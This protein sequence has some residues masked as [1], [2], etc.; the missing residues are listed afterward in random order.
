[1]NVFGNYSKYYD[2]LYQDK[3]YV[4]EVEYVHGLIQRYAS[5]AK[6]IIELGCGTGNHANLLHQKGYVLDGIDISETMLV[7]A[8]S[9]FPHI[10]FH[11]GDIREIKLSMKADVV[12][13][14]FHV[15]S[16]Q[17]TNEDLHKT[18]AT[19]K[20]QLNDGGIFIFDCWY[21]PAVLTNRPVVRVAGARA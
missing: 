8:R 1:M 7:E 10:R 19:V 2:L 20:V 6:S 3:D 16:Y 9:R 5:R 4:G 12:I 15:M 21:G 18:F 17:R 14:L 13:S 11:H